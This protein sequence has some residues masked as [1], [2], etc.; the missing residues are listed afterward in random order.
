MF[1][2]NLFILYIYLALS[3]HPVH[4]SITNVEY[5][6]EEKKME[7]SV[8]VFKADMQLLFIH[9]D[10][11]NIDF[12]NL[13]SIQK[14]IN[15]ISNYFDSHLNIISDSDNK[16]KFN[17]LEF[18]GDWVLFY[19]DLQV[20]NLKDEFFIANSI[21]FDLFYDQKN[22]LIFSNDNREKGF[23]FNSESKKQLIKLNELQV[24]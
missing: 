20:N 16:M 2:I 17:M 11:V 6:Q 10:Q 1:A 21:M 8:K 23:M 13:D 4:V 3:V 18:E 24:L 7:I 14:N 15:R 19:Y 22:M 12:N 5:K 9:L